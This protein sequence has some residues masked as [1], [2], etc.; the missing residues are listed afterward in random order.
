M[1]QGV[2][3]QIGTLS[4]IEAEAHLFQVGRKM[5]GADPM[6]RSHNAAFEKRE[7]G[8]DGI[9]VNVSHDVHTRAVIDFLVIRSLRFT[10]RSL[11]S[12]CV[13][14]EDNLNILR[15]V[16]ADVLSKR[17]AFGILSMKEAEIAIAFTDANDHFLVIVLADL[18]FAAILTT[19]V[20]HIQF[21][22]AVQHWLVGLRHCVPD[23][24]AEVPCCFVAHSDRALNLASGHA[25][26]CFAEEMRGKKPF[27]EREMG[28]IENRAGSDGEL[29]V[30]V[31]A[32]EQLLFSFKLDHWTLATQAFR[33][34]GPAET[35]QKLAALVFS[36][37][38]D[39]YIN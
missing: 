32:V 25:F 5:L 19:N 26:L 3:E 4:A 39:V 15:N 13:V 18:A 10:H 37:E 30:T 17:P 29:I 33:A 1:T 9:G 20:G 11:I 14:R 34:I 21:D 22:F 23:A 38:Q 6:P 36:R 31:L 7:S 12:G 27:A 28:I 24:V 35:D 8:F 2:N 16:L